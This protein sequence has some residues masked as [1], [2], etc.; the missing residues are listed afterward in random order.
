MSF[1]ELARDPEILDLMS[2]AFTIER[3]RNEGTYLEK[4][5]PKYWQEFEKAQKAMKKAKGK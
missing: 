1:T 2:I 5:N 3:G 4:V